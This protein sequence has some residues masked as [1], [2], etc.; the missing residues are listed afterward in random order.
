MPHLIIEYSANVEDAIALDEL[1]DKLHACALETGVFPLGGLRVRAHKT[2]HYRVADKSPEN[3]FVHVTALIGHGRALDVQQRAGEQLFE[4]LT[5]HLAPL[6][7]RSPLAISLNIQEF[8]PVLN[9]KKNNLHEHVRK[10]A[11][12]AG[13]GS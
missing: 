6:Y 11:K 3:G 9:F 7:D 5:A 13:A 4:T 1:L 12:R 10:R 8:H 2:E